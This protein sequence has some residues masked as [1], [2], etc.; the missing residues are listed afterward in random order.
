MRPTKAVIDLDALRHN[1]QTVQKIAPNSR[2][3]AVV[4]ANAYG[5]GLSKV[6][7]A[8]PEAEM[9]AVATPAE[10]YTLRKAG[11]QQPI[12]LLEGFFEARELPKIVNNDLQIV[13]HHSPQIEA[14]ANLNTT[15]K[16]KVWLKVDSGMNRLGFKIDELPEIEK[17]LATI[18]CIEKPI[19][20]MSH[21]ASADDVNDSFT[22]QQLETFVSTTKHLTWERSMANSAGILEAKDAHF[23]WIRPGLILYGCSP[24]IG[25]VG[26]DYGLQPVMNLESQIM[27]IKNLK[28]G[29]STGYGRHWFAE[30]DTV[31]GLV[32]IGYGDGYPR[33]AKNGTPV[34]VNGRTVPLVGRVSMDM[35]AVELGPDHNENIGD[36]VVLWG[37]ELPAEIVAEHADTIPYTL[38]CGVTGRVHMIYKGKRW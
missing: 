19:R 18:E 3:I 22:E 15:K 23:D 16:I 26:A 37:K 25:S 27:S 11:I 12:L 17:Q 2:V 5:H 38:S 20:L 21:F 35:L 13:V 33:H 31:I 32:A 1:F 7:K 14:L 9:F 28:K 29:E 6:A 36:R 30:K 10:A 4:K 24:M 8:L 34:W